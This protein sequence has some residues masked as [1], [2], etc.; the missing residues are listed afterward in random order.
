MNSLPPESV[1]ALSLTCTNFKN[2]FGPENYQKV[3]SCQKQDRFPVPSRS[4]VAK[5]NCC[6][7]CRRLHNIKNVLRYNHATY[8]HG[9]AMWRHRVPCV[10]A[11]VR[12]DRGD[13]VPAISSIFGSTTVKMGVKRDFQ[14][15]GCTEVLKLMSTQTA[16]TIS[17]GS[18]IRQ[19]IEEFRVV[20][21]H[22]LHRLGRVYISC[23]SSRSLDESIFKNEPPRDR[24]CPHIEK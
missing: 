14:Q 17:Q 2:L 24:L 18:Y 23:Y 16:E 10:P 1:A 3:N 8:A 20:Q 4:R 19:S 11:C 6:V 22:L 21:G 15:P 7:P 13:M 12:R 9:I 5:P